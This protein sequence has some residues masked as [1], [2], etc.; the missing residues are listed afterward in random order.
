MSLRLSINA[1]GGFSTAK[2]RKS[3]H[4]RLPLALFFTNRES[5]TYENKA[6]L[7]WQ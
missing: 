6:F 3:M 1:N 4:Q 2:K 5:H 7:G